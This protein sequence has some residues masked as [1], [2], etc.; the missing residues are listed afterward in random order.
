MQLE[1]V[2]RTRSSALTQVVVSQQ[3]GFAMETMTVETCP[4]NRTAACPLPGQVTTIIVYRILY[5][6]LYRCHGLFPLLFVPSYVAKFTF[7]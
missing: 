1:R 2:R 7:I 5:A 6:V 4:M 3:D